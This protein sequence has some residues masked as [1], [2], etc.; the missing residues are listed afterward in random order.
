MVA[1]QIARQNPVAAVG[2]DHAIAFSEQEVVIA[3]KRN[4]VRVTNHSFAPGQGNHRWQGEFATQSRSSLCS[5]M[6]DHGRVA[7]SPC[8]LVGRHVVGRTIN[9]HPAMGHAADAER[10][11]SHEI[12]CRRCL[13]CRALF[14]RCMVRNGLKFRKVVGCSG[15]P[16]VIR[17]RDRRTRIPLLFRRATRIEAGPLG[18]TRTLYLDLRRIALFQ[19]SYEQFDWGVRPGS[20]RLP[21]EPQSRALPHEL[22]TPLKRLGRKDSN[23]RY[24]RV[25]NPVPWTAWRLPN[26]MD[27]RDGVEPSSSVLQTAAGPLGY[28]AIRNGAH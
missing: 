2:A 14:L 8:D 10:K 1:C 12:S 15:T 20:N 21:R 9:V 16:A 11:N 19:V 17:T 3:T 25:Q 18:E 7:K 27:A 4:G 5:S 6:Q 26:L 13:R 24:C 28:R 22:R 23:L